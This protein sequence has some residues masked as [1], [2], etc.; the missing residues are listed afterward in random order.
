[1]GQVILRERVSGE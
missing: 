1:V